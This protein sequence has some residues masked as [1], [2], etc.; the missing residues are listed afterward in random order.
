MSSYLNT[1]TSNR[2]YQKSHT[3]FSSIP[4]YNEHFQN[5]A[6]YTYSENNISCGKKSASNINNSDLN[7]QCFSKYHLLLK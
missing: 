2:I 4:I 6:N 5:N 1:C 3:Q 7:K